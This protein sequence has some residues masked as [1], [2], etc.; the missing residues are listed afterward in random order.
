MTPQA[1]TRG[2]GPLLLDEP[3]A[4]QL[5]NRVLAL[6]TEVDE[7]RVNISSDWSGNTRFADASISTSGGVTNTSVTI[8][9]TIGRKR[10]SASTNVLED[11]SLKRTVELAA[12]LARLSPEDPELMPELGAQ[13]YRPTNAYVQRTV[14]LDPEVRSGA[15]SRAVE[16][17]SN[18]GRSATSTVTLPKALGTSSV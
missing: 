14:M 9:V 18:T 7:T 16:S 15:V 1:S 12:T 2:N 3:Q 4:R 13:S 8:T 10:A 11:D 5:A 6:A 17:A